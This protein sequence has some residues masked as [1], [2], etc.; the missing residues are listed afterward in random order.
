MQDEEI[1]RAMNAVTP[2]SSPL[3]TPKHKK[4]VIEV[5]MPPNSRDPLL[6][7]CNDNEEY[8][9]QLLLPLKKI[10]KRRN[11]KKK[12]ACSSSTKEEVVDE[13]VEVKHFKESDGE[14]CEV[15]T[16]SAEK[17]PSERIQP[18]DSEIAQDKNTTENKV[19]SPQ[20]DK[21]KGN[22]GKVGNKFEKEDKNK[23]RLKG[24]EEPKD[25]RLRKVMCFPFNKYL[26]Y[27][28][29]LIICA[30]FSSISKNLLSFIFRTPR[31]K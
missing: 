27:I 11:K 14:H 31:I 24:L 23:L 9:K 16:S 19:E 21:S 28:D 22:I 30:I 6:L 18:T 4:D 17:S 1:N 26:I 15:V 29:I 25:K 20:K 2:K 3:P 13:A 12:R 7:T 10:S 8:E 5:L